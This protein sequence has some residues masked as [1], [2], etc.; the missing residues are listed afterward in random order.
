MGWGW[1]LAQRM[2]MIGKPAG[3]S[4]S[5]SSTFTTRGSGGL[6]RRLVEL[7]WELPGLAAV[8]PSCTVVVGAGRPWT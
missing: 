7:S 1:G 3:G 8:G 4:T 2:S 5:S 6:A